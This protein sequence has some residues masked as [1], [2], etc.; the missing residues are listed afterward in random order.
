M[1]TISAKLGW[2]LSFI[3]TL[4]SRTSRTLRGATLTS[5][6]FVEKPVAYCQFSKK[7]QA[8]Q[9]YIERVT[10]VENHLFYSMMPAC[11]KCTACVTTYHVRSLRSEDLLVLPCVCVCVCVR[12]GPGVC[13]GLLA[14]PYPL[15]VAGCTIQPWADSSVLCKCK[16]A[17]SAKRTKV[18]P[19]TPN[20]YLNYTR[21]GWDMLIKIW[22]KKLHYW[23]D[24]TR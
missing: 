14:Y 21:R 3:L 16:C 4:F 1:T 9:S 8:V 20:K 11:L 18:H 17:D 7:W 12:L 15:P 2:L 19:S 24:P 22:R 13:P 6:T 23:D 5:Q 10:S